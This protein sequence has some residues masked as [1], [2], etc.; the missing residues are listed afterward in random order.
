LWLTA[1][2]IE[3]CGSEVRDNV[4]LSSRLLLCVGL[5]C[6]KQKTR[7]MRLPTRVVPLASQAENWGGTAA[8]ITAGFPTGRKGGGGFAFRL[9]VTVSIAQKYKQGAACRRECKA[10]HG[11]I[12]VAVAVEIAMAT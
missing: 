7:S 11:E 9:S 8:I 5:S 4:A 3:T 12:R 2:Q 10:G 6:C 1:R